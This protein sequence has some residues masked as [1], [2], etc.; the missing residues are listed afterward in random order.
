MKARGNMLLHLK[1]DCIELKVWTENLL[2]GK[3][4]KI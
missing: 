1:V 4:V 3:K 2:A